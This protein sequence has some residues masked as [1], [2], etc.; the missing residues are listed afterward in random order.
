MPQITTA[1][2]ISSIKGKMT[3]VEARLLKEELMALLEGEGD[4]LL[5]LSDVEDMD[6]AGFQLLALLSRE[7]QAAGRRAVRVTEHSQ[8]TQEIIKTFRA[9]ELGQ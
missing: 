2:G 7:A 1:D 4:I 6:S 8:A 3:V 9:N 5:D